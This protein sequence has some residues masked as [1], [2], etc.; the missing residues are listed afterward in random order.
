MRDA[1]VFPD[2]PA[3]TT[4]PA[5]LPSPPAATARPLQ[6]GDLTPQWRWIMIAGWVALIASMVITAGA[7]EMLH[8]SVWWIGDRADPAPLVFWLI[9]FVLPVAVISLGL[10]GRRWLTEVSAVASVATLAVAFGDRTNSP[11]A[12][13]VMAALGVAGLLLTAASLGGRVRRA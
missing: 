9:P 5:S 2:E 6:P 12:A 10:S 11:S 13:V 7:A 4:A 3:A 8:R 1:P